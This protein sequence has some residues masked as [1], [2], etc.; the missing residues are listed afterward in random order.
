[1]QVVIREENADGMMTYSKKT[2]LW[3]ETCSINVVYNLKPLF[4]G[5]YTRQK[6]SY[7]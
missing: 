2:G 5:Q 6:Q 1:M 4:L 3:T 7:T